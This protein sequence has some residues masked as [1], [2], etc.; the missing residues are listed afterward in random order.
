MLPEFAYGWSP[1][2]LR[3][4]RLP[5]VRSSV[6][7]RPVTPSVASNRD[8]MREHPARKLLE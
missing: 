7:N 4:A 3:Q 6:S 2:R 1:G 8:Q 5:V